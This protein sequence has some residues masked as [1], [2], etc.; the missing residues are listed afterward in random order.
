MAL[1]TF[2][3]SE[4]Q[5][6]IDA[7]K[8]CHDVCLRM[9]MTHCLQKGGQHVEEEH[10]RLMLN[11]AEICQ[12]AANFMLS[13]S[14]VH[15][16]VCAACAKICDACAHSCEQ[17]GDMDECVQ[18]CRQCAESCEE[19]ARSQNIGGQRQQSSGAAARM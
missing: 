15:D 12:T 14:S 10:F 6:C 4:M 7:C 1:Q 3:N 9:A 16:V 19:M 13:N 17:I 2:Q 18:T 11:C 8:R 5:R